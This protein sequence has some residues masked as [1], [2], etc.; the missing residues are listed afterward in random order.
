MSELIQ[1]ASAAPSCGSSSCGPAIVCYTTA[2]HETHAVGAAVAGLVTAGDVVK[3]VGDLG[4]GKTAFVQGFALRLSVTVPVTS[5][6]FTL[7]NRYDGELTVNHLDVYRLA[8]IREAQ[9][10]ALPE[11]IDEGVTLIEWGDMIDP[12]LPSEHLAVNIRFPSVHP[13]LPVSSA[14]SVSYVTSD[15]SVLYTSDN[16]YVVQFPGTSDITPG[17]ASDDRKMDDCRIIELRPEGEA[18]KLRALDIKRAVSSWIA[19]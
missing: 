6:T 3:L 15:P 4:A 11:L 5:P 17:S 1:S 2:V 8:D 13:V 16:G 19:I 7:A 14:P 18:W 10:L 12:L 9:D